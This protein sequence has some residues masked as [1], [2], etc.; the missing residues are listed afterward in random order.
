VSPRPLHPT[1]PP[2]TL[3]ETYRPPSELNLQV[4]RPSKPKIRE[5]NPLGTKT[6]A[7]PTHR[8]T[9]TME[10]KKMPA[11]HNTAL[12]SLFSS[13]TTSVSTSWQDSRLKIVKLMNRTDASTQHDTQCRMRTPANQQPLTML[14]HATSTNPSNTRHHNEDLQCH[15]YGGRPLQLNNMLQEDTTTPNLAYAD[16]M[17]PYYTKI[18]EKVT[19]QL[20]QHQSNQY[21]NNIT[22]Q[23]AMGNNTSTTATS[24]T[25]NDV[26]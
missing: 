1:M 25:Q 23:T 11:S 21:K 12:P 15:I 6:H 24:S 10:I 14:P 22:N 4:E 16:T 3:R 8:P 7:E 5:I 26:T 13:P 2:Y 17:T 20:P 18:P 9:T 19:L